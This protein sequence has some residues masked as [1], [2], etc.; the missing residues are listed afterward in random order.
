M[1]ANPDKFG[2][3]GFWD[4]L[5]VKVPHP[6]TTMTNVLG[7]FTN[8]S[9]LYYDYVCDNERICGVANHQRT[10]EMYWLDW[11][12]IISNLPCQCSLKRSICRIV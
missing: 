9:K 3:G 11:V 1:D 4:F 5:V 8:P 7:I 10:E 2:S 6:K 12:D